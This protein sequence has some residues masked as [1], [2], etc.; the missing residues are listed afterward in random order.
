MPSFGLRFVAGM[1][2]FLLAACGGAAGSPAP[3]LTP[4]V[5]PSPS[6]VQ[7]AA[8][9]HNWVENLGFGGD[10][11]GTMK[12]VVASQPGQ[13]SECTGRNSLSGGS[14]AS[15]IFGNVGSEVYGLVIVANPYRGPG[16]YRDRQVSV[17]V[18]SLDNLR[19]WQSVAADPVTFVVAADQESGTL[20]ASLDN[21]T[22]GKT[23][24]KITGAWTCR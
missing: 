22:T 16:T 9:S 8:V 5:T 17:Q 21:L 1:V 23:S 11:S 3:T 6:P 13:V 18:H 2:L 24:L 4:A 20:E 15:S 10:V 7:S 14:W 12:S 19:V